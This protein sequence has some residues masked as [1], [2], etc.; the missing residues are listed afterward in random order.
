MRPLAPVHWAL[1][2]AATALVTLAS[3]YYWPI[4][5]TR[6]VSV[7]W[8]MWQG[9]SFLVPLKNGLPYSH[10]P[11]LLFWLVHAGWAAFGVNDWWPRLISP[12]FAFASLLLCRAVAGRLW[13]GQDGLNLAVPTV[14]LG[15]ALW[16]IYSQ[17]LMF[18]ILL[19]FWVLLGIWALVRQAER[20]GWRWWAVFGLAVGLGILS[21][22]PVALLH[23]LPPAL[24]APW[25]AGGR[26]RIARW[27]AGVL[28]A[29]LLGVAIVLAW[30]VPAGQAG[31]EAYRDAIFL[32]QTLGRVA[33]SE[34]PHQQP[35]WWYLPWLPLLLFPWLAWPPVYRG[36]GALSRRPPDDGVRL[37]LSWA[38]PALLGFTLISGKQF[39]YLIPDLPAY[40]MLIVRSLAAEES[41]QRP[42]APAL[43]ILLLGAVSIGLAISGVAQE[44]GLVLS[45][46][47]IPGFLLVVAVWLRGGPG[48]AHRQIPALALG[49]AALHAAILYWAIGPIST[50]YDVR[51]V[52]RAIQAQQAA[53]RPVA[54]DSSYHDQ[55]QFAGRLA[56]PLVLVPSGNTGRWASEHP[57]G[58][59]LMYVRR[60]E[61]PAGVT[62]IIAHPYRSRLALLLTAADA[63]KL[64]EDGCPPCR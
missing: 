5:E 7:A 22:G 61:V 57:D 63:R 34:A 19:G 54:H 60:G 13:P 45:P 6:Y 29:T 39:H 44:R 53:G 11:P 31:G 14:L 38:L 3:R 32:G 64:T 9:D 52:A 59:V 23:L 40:A 50:A 24:L 16:L 33:G 56:A 21:K 46:W 30:A 12:G 43:L 55:Y 2:L 4:V 62:P 42:W 48:H 47:L 51:P 35:F 26:V 36:L 25:W 28:G 41:R 49:M 27:Y 8:E 1:L 17:A 18:D 37:A 58:A 10:K 15:S 20:P